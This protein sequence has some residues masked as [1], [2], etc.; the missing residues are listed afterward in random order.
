MGRTGCSMDKDLG[1]VCLGLLGRAFFLPK[2]DTMQKMPHFL[3]QVLAHVCPRTVEAVILQLWGAVPQGQGTVPRRRQRGK[4]SESPRQRRTAEPAWTS[5]ILVLWDSKGL[6]CFRLHKLDFFVPWSMLTNSGA[7][8]L[9]TGLLMRD[10]ECGR[11]ALLMYWIYLRFEAC[12][13]LCQEHN[14]IVF[15][16]K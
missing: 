15:L 4:E 16:G 2:R 3:G 6:R 12:Q 14:P 7:Y 13:F 10:L 8:C 11:F 5:P 9:I 1:D